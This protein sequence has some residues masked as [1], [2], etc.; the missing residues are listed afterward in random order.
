MTEAYLKQYGEVTRGEPAR[1]PRNARGH[2]R[3]SGVS[4]VAVEAVMNNVG[5]RSVVDKPLFGPLAFVHDA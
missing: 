2:A 1:W 3:R 5:Y 4:A